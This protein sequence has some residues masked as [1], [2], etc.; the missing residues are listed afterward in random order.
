[1]D[2]T[3]ADDPCT[4]TRTG[5]LTYGPEDHSFQIQ[6]MEGFFRGIEYEHFFD[7]M[8]NG[9]YLVYG[10]VDTIN[11]GP[12]NRRQIFAQRY[13]SMFAKEVGII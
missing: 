9:D 13:D 10:A 8:P 1:M 11:C 6:E 2:S 12:T 3:H 5:L 4:L 7:Y